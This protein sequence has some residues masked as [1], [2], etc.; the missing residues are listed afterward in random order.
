MKNYI[1]QR[2]DG[3]ASADKWSKSMD[4]SGDLYRHLQT[5]VDTMVK[6][7]ESIRSCQDFTNSV[8]LAVTGKTKKKVETHRSTSYITQENVQHS[9]LL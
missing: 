6:V 5:L 2:R 1:A 8:A 4:D 9:E 7:N 3:V